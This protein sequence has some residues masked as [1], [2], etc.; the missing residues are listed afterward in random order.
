MTVQRYIALIRTH[1]ITS[2]K[3]V[4]K[5]RKSAHLL[6]L[7]HVLL[8]SGGSPGIMY[9]QG[10]DAS[11]VDG[12]VTAVQALRYKD[13]QCVSKA[14]E[15]TL[16]EVPGPLSTFKEVPT[17]PEFGEEMEKRGLGAW[18]KKGMGY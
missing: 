13:Y 11:A 18:W 8:R 3:K 4:Q 17:V 15:E 16:K 10:T 1:H 9:A 2:R 5:L 14:S 6:D 12:W 7:E